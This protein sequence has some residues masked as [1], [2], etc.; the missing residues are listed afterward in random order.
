MEL[1]SHMNTGA[2]QECT[3]LP[4]GTRCINIGSW[5]LRVGRGLGQPGEA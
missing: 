3:H 1:H 4:K 2:K 5:A